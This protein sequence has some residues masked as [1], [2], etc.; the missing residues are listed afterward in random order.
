MHILS[1]LLSAVAFL[2]LIFSLHLLF[3]SKGNPLLNRLLG[4]PLLARLGQVCVFLLLSS[5]YQN[6]IPVLQK[7]CVPLFFLAPVCSY[8]Y[9]RGFIYS[10]LRL[11]KRDLIHLVPAILAVIHVLPIPLETPLNW[12]A[13]AHQIIDGGQLSISERTGL[14]PPQVYK[15]GLFLVSAGYLIASWFIVLSSGYISKEHWDAGKKWLTFY[16]SMATLFRLLSFSALMFHFMERSY[17]TSTGFL[18][19]SCLALLFMMAFVLYQPQIL[20][21]YI[22]ISDAGLES[23][24]ELKVESNRKTI[25]PKSTITLQQQT[26]YVE[27]IQDF[28]KQKQ[29]YLL[30][31]FQI[32]DLAHAVGIPIHYCSSVINNALDKNF[33]DWLNGYRIMYFIEEYPALSDKLTIEAVAYQSGFKNVT[34]FYNAFKK[35][36]GQMPTAYFV[37][38][39]LNQSLKNSN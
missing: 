16:L 25:T 4:L 17:M 39:E 24:S 27:K 15:A 9:I 20:Y 32:K 12:N 11:R 34:T 30:P 37:N 36:T 10:E 13:I 23:N 31:D 3:T 26:E 38:K 8:L 18:L 33:R 14:F 19:V 28:M 6:A 22:I 21:G 29:P 35:E 2:L 7:I 5:P 1:L